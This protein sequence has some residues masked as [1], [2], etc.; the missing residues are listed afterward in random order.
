MIFG[1]GKR[2]KTIQSKIFL[3]ANFLPK[4][5]WLAIKITNPSAMYAP[6]F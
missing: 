3:Y 4:K 6:A 2:L 5:I 1:F